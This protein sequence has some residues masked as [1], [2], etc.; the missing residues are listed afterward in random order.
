M[1]YFIAQTLAGCQPSQHAAAHD[2]ILLPQAAAAV[3]RAHTPH[4]QQCC[5]SPKVS[6]ALQVSEAARVLSNADTV[7]EVS[8]GCLL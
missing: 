8:C 6:E 7:S 2:G 3:Y 5:I 4:L 1:A